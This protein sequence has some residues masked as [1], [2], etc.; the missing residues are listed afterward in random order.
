M[1][2]DNDEDG[3]ILKA[4]VVPTTL[5]EVR[6]IWRWPVLLGAVSALGLIC[7]LVGDGGY[8]ILSWCLLALPLIVIGYALRRADRSGS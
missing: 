5:P 1:K 4:A 7:A 2:L 3:E 6:K 8:D